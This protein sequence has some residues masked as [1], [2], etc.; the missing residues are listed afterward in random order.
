[1]LS[2]VRHLRNKCRTLPSTMNMG[3]DE[4]NGMEVEVGRHQTT[5]TPM[6]V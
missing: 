4:V 6:Y 1:M 5:E 3:W 2:M